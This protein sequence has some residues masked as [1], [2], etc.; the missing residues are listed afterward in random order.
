MPLS[1]T[2]QE[3]TFFLSERSNC[4]YIERFGEYPRVY[5]H[6]RWQ[7]PTKENYATFYRGFRLVLE[8][9]NFPAILIF[10][11]FWKISNSATLGSRSNLRLVQPVLGKDLA[12]VLSSGFLISFSMEMWSLWQF[13]H[14]VSTLPGNLNLGNS[15][16]Q[17]V[18][19][20]QVWFLRHPP[21]H[22]WPTARPR[23]LPTA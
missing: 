15:L 17:A 9:R 1:G 14:K 2:Q 7:M 18:A 20:S 3:K 6:S 10:T 16:L 12:M 13:L 21:E 5:K 23:S 4:L 11:G 19:H 22:L 8:T